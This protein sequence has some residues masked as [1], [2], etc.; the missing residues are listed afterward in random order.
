VPSPTTPPG[1]EAEFLS[2]VKGEQITAND[3]A[4]LYAGHQACAG[5]YHG[6]TTDDMAGDFTD[7]TGGSESKAR[8]LINDAQVFLC[9]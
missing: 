6:R 9:P 8:A 2:A 4:L 7:L 1:G 5:F 3:E